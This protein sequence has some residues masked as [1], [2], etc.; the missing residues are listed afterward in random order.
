[1]VRHGVGGVADK[2]EVALRGRPGRESGKGEEGPAG[3]PQASS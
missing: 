3:L 2:H 1:M